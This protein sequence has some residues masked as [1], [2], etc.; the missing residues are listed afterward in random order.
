MKALFVFLLSLILSCFANAQNNNIVISIK[1]LDNKPDLAR[2][3]SNTLSNMFTE[4]Y[5]A[6]NDTREPDLRNLYISGDTQTKI[7]AL[8]KRHKF[9]LPGKSCVLGAAKLY[10]R[11]EYAVFSV[12]MQV[13]GERNMV[14]YIIHFNSYGMITNFERAA[15]PLLNFNTGNRVVDDQTKGTIKAMLYQLR[16]AYNTKDSLY[17]RKIYDPNGYCLVGK[18]AVGQSLSNPSNEIRIYL[19]QQQYDITIK[20]LSEYLNDLNKVFKNN[21]WIHINFGVPEITAHQSPDSKFDGIYYITVSQDYKSQ[22]YSDFGWLTLVLNLRDKSN[23]LIL[24]R[25]WLPEKI[26]TKQLSNLF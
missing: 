6:Y 23:P 8:W 15:F 13:M 10:N 17:L 4:F 2:S 21:S 9:R 16:N 25:I 18:K 22:T 1:Y 19:E 14:E 24:A 20:K 11:N 26:T 3:V 7:L 5:L 12:P